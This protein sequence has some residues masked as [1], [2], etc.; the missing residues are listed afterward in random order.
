M[1]TRRTL[2]GIAATL[3]AAGAASVAVEW[4]NLFGPHFKPTPY[5]DLLTRLEDRP[6]A[7]RLGAVVLAA[8]PGFTPDAAAKRLR[9]LL[10][11]H[12]LSAAAMADVTDG[13]MVEAGGWILPESVALL[14][15]LAAKTM[16][17]SPQ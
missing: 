1:K 3:A 15:A 8:I 10:G 7:A 11:A 14:S 13:R 4:R 2:I 9:A 16:P 17:A 12:G 6:T 5:D